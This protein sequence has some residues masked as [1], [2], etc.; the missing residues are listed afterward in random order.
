MQDATSPSDGP[1]GEEHLADVA[2]D[3]VAFVDQGSASGYLVP[4]L[5]LLNAGVDPE[6]DITPLFAGS[7]DDAVQAVYDGDAQVGTSFNDA[8]TL[9]TDQLPDVGEKVVVFAWSAPIPNDGFAVAG[10]LPQDLKDGITAALLDIASTPARPRDAVDLRHRRAA[11]RLT[12]RTS[13]SSARCAPSCPT[14]C[15]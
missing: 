2:G 10:D 8:R 9:L 14:C 13:T 15:E 5:E 4:S 6:T 3:T 7:H 12:R 11:S 1:I